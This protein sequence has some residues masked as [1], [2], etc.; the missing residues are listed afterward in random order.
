MLIT[1]ETSRSVEALLDLRTVDIEIVITETDGMRVSVSSLVNELYAPKGN[2]AFCVYLAPGANVGPDTFAE[3]AIFNVTIIPNAKTDE[4][5]N[6]VEQQ[7]TSVGGCTV[8]YTE[9][10]ADGGYLVA[11]STPNDY[12]NLKKID[13][14]Y[15]EG[16]MASFV[17]TATGLGMTADKI[18]VSDYSGMASLYTNN[19]G[20]VEEVRVILLDNDREFAIIDQVGKSSVPNLNTVII[21]N[22]KTVKPG[23]KVD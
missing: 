2:P 10:M 18:V 6:P 4:E 15:T 17:D 22:P 16:Y 21:I 7:N 23:D 20:F 3:N 12:S 8:I 11:F 13:R 14:L 9:A 19:Q 5:G 1:F